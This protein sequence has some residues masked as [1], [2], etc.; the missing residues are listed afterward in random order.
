MLIVFLYGS[1]I[2]GIFPID[3]QTSWEGH[4]T[5]FASG[6]ILAIFF[7]KELKSRY[8][9][10]DTLSEEEDDDDEDDP[11]AYWKQPDTT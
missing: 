4:L 11:D 7:R 9:I 2:W 3:F 10:V 5:G 1:I 6:I 8:L